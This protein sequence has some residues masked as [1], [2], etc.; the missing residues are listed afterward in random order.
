MSKKPEVKITGESQ[1]RVN[2]KWVAIILAILIVFT[3][4]VGWM[5]HVTATARPATTTSGGY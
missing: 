5:Y 3:F 1:V 2:K 4:G